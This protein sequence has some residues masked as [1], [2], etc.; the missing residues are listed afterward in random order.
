MRNTIRLT[1]ILLLITIL[2]SYGQS[3]SPVRLDSLFK[4]LERSHQA[5]G[6]V[7]ISKDGKV[8]Y[9]RAFGMYEPGKIANTLTQYRIGSITKTF[10]AVMVL[11]LAKEHKLA[12][13][14]SISKYFPQVAGSGKITID[15][16][17]GHT[18]G[19]HDFTRD[20]DYNAYSQQPT[21][22]A[23][24]LARIARYRPDFAA[25]QKTVY[26]STNYLLLGYI[27]EHVTGKNYA[28][29]LQQ[30]IT[31]KLGLQHTTY[32]Y[33]LKP[34]QASS[35]NFNGSA[36]VPVP[37][38]QLS[39]P[40][41]AGGML[42]TPTDL[43]QFIRSLFKF[44][45]LT[46]DAVTSMTPAT[47]N[48]GRGLIQVPVADQMGYGHF[49]IIDGFKSSLIYLPQS[50]L[51]LA[52]CLNSA[53]ADDNA[54]VEQTL[55]ITLQQLSNNIKLPTAQLSK[56]V[57]TYVSRQ[58]TLPITLRAAGGYLLMQAGDRQILNLETLSPTRFR[59]AKG[60][61]IIDFGSNPA[62][63]TLKQVDKVYEYYKQ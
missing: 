49:G 3:F 55:N 51:A 18:S 40:G 12:L 45:L 8:I 39:V 15:Q 61:M 26:S 23:Q 42:S 47:G 17:L 62:H 28:A 35:Y 46:A 1:I 33:G 25:G 5:M 37:P 6:S 58:A 59:L 16:L 41:G 4:A 60:A 57:G 56:Y 21:T 52:V 27:I 31:A 34:N 54:V 14:T 43:V 53:N 13:N 19:L 38:T 36:W 48:L 44:K 22:K 10:T 32:Q 29:N 7:C 9:S 20:A 50:D 63:F 11:Q 24:M 30:R 2:H